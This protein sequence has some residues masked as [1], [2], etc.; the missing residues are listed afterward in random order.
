MLKS[1]KCQTSFLKRLNHCFILCIFTLFLCFTGCGGDKEKQLN[2]FTWANY[3]S[4][5]IRT[6]FEKEF[7]VKVIMDIFPDNEDLLAKLQ[8]GAKGYDIIMPSDYMVSIMMKN[9]MLA[10][11]NRENIPNFKNI[12]SDFL[13]KYFDPENLYSIPYTFGTAGIA[14]DSSVVSPAP[15]S[16]QIL[17]DSTYENQ[18]SMLDDPRETIGVALKLLGYSLNSND[19][20]QLRQAKEKL[21][22]QRPLLKQYESET[23]DI[24]ISK[25]VVIAHSWSGDALKAAEQNP[26]IRYIIPKE[27]SSQFIDTV[28]IPKTAP[29][30]ALAEKFINYL[31]RPEINAKITEFTK[32]GTCVPK[33]KE[34]LP[35][36][37]QKH[38]YI[39][40]STESMKSLESIIDPGD[41][42]PEY[43]RT[44]DEIKAK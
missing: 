10:E 34:H 40:P 18:I 16:W 13:G 27:G 35:E 6:G 42:M 43:S 28:C 11:I 8:A 15:D 21:I 30:K 9:E 20:D 25:E 23:Q 32:Y 1:S 39:Y 26:S 38:E 12:S 24:L 17:W 31:L 29:N 44:W 22:E 3:V 33:A 37:L 4:N 41:F 5:E 19:V 7:G 14:Y 36:N 2:I